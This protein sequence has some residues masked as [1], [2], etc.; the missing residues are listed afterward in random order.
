M[1]LALDLLQR[2]LDVVLNMVGSRIMPMDE[3]WL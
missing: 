1:R 2:C 3:D